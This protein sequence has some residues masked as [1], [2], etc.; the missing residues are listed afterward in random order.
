MD[1]LVIYFYDDKQSADIEVEGRVIRVVEYGFTLSYP[2]FRLTVTPFG[3]IID[4]DLDMGVAEVGGSS[5]DH[6]EYLITDFD[7]D[8]LEVIEFE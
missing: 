7:L 3:D 1:S 4:E 2:G 6:V 8:K 5:D